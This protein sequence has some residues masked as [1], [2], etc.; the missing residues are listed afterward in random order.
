MQICSTQK[1]EEKNIKSQ[2]VHDIWR[3]IS[4]IA[5]FPQQRA[6]PHPFKQSPFL[7]TFA[8]LIFHVPSLPFLPHVCVYNMASVSTSSLLP[9]TLLCHGYLRRRQLFFPHCISTY[10]K[11]LEASAP[12]SVLASRGDRTAYHTVNRE[13][14]AHLQL[15]HTK[16]NGTMLHYYMNLNTYDL[17]IIGNGWGV[18]INMREFN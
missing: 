8:L 14:R 10:M 6:Q 3:E 5:P 15:Q 12:K 17:G 11:G 7:I 4:K 2:F 16:T 13:P 1:K 9:A 18:R